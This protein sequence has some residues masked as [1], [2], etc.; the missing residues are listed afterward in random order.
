MK[1]QAANPSLHI[2]SLSI[3]PAS[4][5]PF[6]IS[7]SFTSSPFIAYILLCVSE[8]TTHLLISDHHQQPNQS[9][10]A[11]HEPPYMREPTAVTS[12]LTNPCEL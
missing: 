8:P 10:L 6:F 11:R 4:H 3:S 7:Y 9:G 5:A 1:L 2:P 12:S